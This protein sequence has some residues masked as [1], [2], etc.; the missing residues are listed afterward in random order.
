MNNSAKAE[1][2]LKSLTFEKFEKF[3]EFC[4]LESFV[5]DL[6]SW[7]LVPGSWFLVLFFA[8]SCAILGLAISI[9]RIKNLK[10]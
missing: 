1:G 2:I 4:D 6:G 9:L 8:V 7:F 10:T 5:L 3:E